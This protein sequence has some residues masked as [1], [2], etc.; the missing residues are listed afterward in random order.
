[1]SN[2]N[3]YLITLKYGERKIPKFSTTIEW[4]FSIFPINPTYNSIWQHSIVILIV[5]SETTKFNQNCVNSG[6]KMF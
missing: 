3:P 1:M 2:Y 5:K 6:K 4:F